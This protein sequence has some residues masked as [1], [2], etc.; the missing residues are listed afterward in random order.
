[1]EEL[2]FEDLIDTKWDVRGW[3]KEQKSLW[4]KECF[5]LGLTWNGKVT[6]KHLTATYYF[7]GIYGLTFIDDDYH[8]YFLS[9]SSHQE[10]QF[11]DMFPD[12]EASKPTDVM[13]EIKKLFVAELDKGASTKGSDEDERGFEGLVYVE[14]AS[15]NDLQ[16]FSLSRDVCSDEQWKYAMINLPKDKIFSGINDQ[17]TTV[18]W[19]CDD[20]HWFCNEYEDNDTHVTFND[21][22]QYKDEM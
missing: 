17:T 8:E 3:S 9:K 5:N 12:Y 16:Y 14:P 2:K 13:E 1:M 11:T 19:C 22:F 6:V 21:L 20:K 18:Q 4:Q 10:R 15:T 7:I